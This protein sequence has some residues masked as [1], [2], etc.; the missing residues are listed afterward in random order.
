MNATELAKLTIKELK[1]IAAEIG[2]VP[3]NDKRSKQSWIDIITLT[4]EVNA[5]AQ[6][7]PQTEEEFDAISSEYDGLSEVLC[8]ML[9]N[10]EDTLNLDDADN[11]PDGSDPDS[12]ES[13]P[14]DDDT[15]DLDDAA[16]EPKPQPPQRGASTV[17]LIVI[18]AFGVAFLIIKMGFTSIVWVITALV[19][20]ALKL[21]RYL[22]P[23]PNPLL[24]AE[25]L[26]PNL[27]HKLSIDP[28]GLTL[29]L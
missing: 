14:D 21:W 23:E 25:N 13:T 28:S 26:S 4:R 19:P 7:E 8:E 5:L 22:F 16:L 2:A 11:E 20:L 12:G 1:V 3:T 27:P 15:W 18:L 10:D 29:T 24:D 17:G 9:L 6:A